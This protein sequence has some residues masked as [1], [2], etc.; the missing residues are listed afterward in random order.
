VDPSINELNNNEIILLEDPSVKI[1]ENF[2]LLNNTE[3][4]PF[5]GGMGEYENNAYKYSQHPKH[6]KG[7]DA[8]NT[9][10]TYLCS[11][12]L[13]GVTIIL[14]FYSMRTKIIF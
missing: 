11:V 9:I 4:F 12:G 14:L 3:K 6:N 8:H 2:G 10:V 7:R 5:G 1:D 13:V